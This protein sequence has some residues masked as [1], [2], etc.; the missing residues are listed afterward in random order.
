MLK[1]ALVAAGLLAGVAFAVPAATATSGAA[2]ANCHP[3]VA[4]H[5]GTCVDPIGDVEGTAGPDITRVTQYEWGIIWF[6]VMFAKAGSAGSPLAR[7]DT[8]RDEVS[9]TL[10]AR[11]NT[12]KRYLLT[13]SATDLKHQV[14]QRLPNG[15]RFTLLAT[16]RAVEGKTV[17]LSVNLHPLVGDPTVVRYRIKA[18]RVMLNGTPGSTDYV[19]NTGTMVWYRQ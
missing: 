5:P 15:K 8:F 11:G 17:T 6:R 1:A 13:V 12:T 18:A 16:G 4:G 19:P 14:L 7:G 3:G 2:N 9:V 10:T